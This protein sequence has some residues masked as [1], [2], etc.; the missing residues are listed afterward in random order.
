MPQ[1]CHCELAPANGSRSSRLPRSFWAEVL[2]LSL[3]YS[4][5]IMSPSGFSTSDDREHLKREELTLPKPLHST[6]DTSHATQTLGHP[7]RLW[8]E[9]PSP[10]PL[11]GEGT[12]RA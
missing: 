11:S 9:S 2:F 3:A 4:R 6:I 7:A 5:A 1:R 12:A 8:R 10:A